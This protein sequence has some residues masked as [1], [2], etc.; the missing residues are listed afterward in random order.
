MSYS[1]HCCN[2]KMDCIIEFCN[3]YNTHDPEYFNISNDI[4]KYVKEKKLEINQELLEAELLDDGDI[5]DYIVSV[6]DNE[7]ISLEVLN[8]MNTNKIYSV[9]DRDNKE[10]LMEYLRQ[11]GE[12]DEKENDIDK[13]A[14]KYDY[15]KWED[16]C[17]YTND[18]LLTLCI[19]KKW[20]KFC[21]RLL[22]FNSLHRVKKQNITNAFE[23]S[24][25]NKLPEV[26]EKITKINQIDSKNK[27]DI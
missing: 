16:L 19:E 18:S 23:L 11:I 9:I 20:N 17:H 6:I 3:H 22:D 4:L 24:I 5:L 1:C 10:R 15:D 7:I 12:I 27:V 14:I 2:K 8:M 13:I 26:T 25:K 21:L